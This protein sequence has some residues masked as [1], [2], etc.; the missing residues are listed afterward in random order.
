MRLPFQKTLPEGFVRVREGDLICAVRNDL[1]RDFSEHWWLARSREL[2]SPSPPAVILKRGTYKTL[3]KCT[4]GAISCM[5]KVYRMPGIMRKV[6]GLIKASRPAREFM[7]G[8][9]IAAQGIPTAA[10]LVFAERR[11]LGCVSEGLV[12]VPFIDNA[13]ELREFFFSR[14]IPAVERRWVA[15]AFGRLT[16]EIFAHG[17]FQYDYALNNFLIR[18]DEH[19]RLYF[20]DF[21]KVNIRTVPSHRHRIDILSRLNRV[22]KEVSVRERLLFVRGYCDQ[23]SSNGSPRTCARELFG[24]T[25]A[26]LRKDLAR[27]RT[28]SIYT[29]ARYRRIAR[30]PYSGFCLIAYAVDD[31]IAMVANIQERK[32]VLSARLNDHELMLLMLGAAEAEKAWAMMN[33]FVV[34]GARCDLPE[35]FIR[36][37]HRGCIG[38]TFDTLRSYK[39]FFASSCTAARFLQKTFPEEMQT[40]RQLLAPLVMNYGK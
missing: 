5:V 21:E 27:R 20:I 32:G 10:P 40:L 34:G 9:F 4:L 28:T 39:D 16:A 26:T 6:A 19:G 33:V 23:D 29:H 24:A 38:F 18:R 35:V 17:I 7:A 11:R 36:D 37:A 14:N 31:V 8:C 25:I 15:E 1:C 22:G 13:I 2:L 30:R 3:L 12:I